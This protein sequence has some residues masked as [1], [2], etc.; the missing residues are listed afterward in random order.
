MAT[1]DT[2][3][4]AD[5]QRLIKKR[6]MYDIHVVCALETADKSEL[7]EKVIKDVGS[8]YHLTHF[9]DWHQRWNAIVT[10]SKDC[11][12]ELVLVLYQLYI[13]KLQ[14]C[15]KGKEKFTRLQL[16][17]METMRDV[18][19]LTEDQSDK[20]R[21]TKSYL[22]NPV[23]SSENWQR[24]NVVVEGQLTA[25]RCSIA[26]AKQCFVSLWLVTAK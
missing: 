22:P 16:A 15:R 11:L 25:M 5:K 9:H 8:G 18:I 13:D 1:T 14:L 2:G 4:I 3:M 23:S 6:K 24:W 26:F 10:T 17:W 20:E 7:L 21:I 12:L 19:H